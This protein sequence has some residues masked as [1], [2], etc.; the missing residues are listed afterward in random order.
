MPI[1]FESNKCVFK[2]DEVDRFDITHIVPMVV[3]M[4]IIV[5]HHPAIVARVNAFIDVGHAVCQ[6]LPFLIPDDFVPN[7]SISSLI[8]NNRSFR[9]FRV[10][11]RFC[12]ALQSSRQHFRARILSRWSY[13]QAVMMNHSQRKQPSR[14]GRR[15]ALDR[16][17]VVHKWYGINRRPLDG[18]F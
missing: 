18:R 3:P 16:I 5:A 17:S 7:L 4:S 14:S 15:Q 8:W 13:G 1:G 6:D 11:R 12:H 2:R 10:F 9:Y